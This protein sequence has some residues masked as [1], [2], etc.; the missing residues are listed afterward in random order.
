MFIR[1]LC[2]ERAKWEFRHWLTVTKLR[3][4]TLCR[5]GYEVYLKPVELVTHPAKSEH[6][7]DT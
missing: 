3:G 4:E 1:F 6:A 7:S 5:P 2:S